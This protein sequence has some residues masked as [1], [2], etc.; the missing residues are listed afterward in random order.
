MAMDDTPPN[1]SPTWEDVRAAFKRYHQPE[2]LGRSPLVN[3]P[4][5]QAGLVLDPHTSTLKK[6]GVALQLVLKSAAERL[7]PPPGAFPLDVHPTIADPRWKDSTWQPYL[8]L[9]YHYMTS[10]PPKVLEQL[11]IGGSV[12]ALIALMGLTDLYGSERKA[13]RAVADLLTEQQDLIT[14][15]K[16]IEKKAS[17]HYC[18]RP[19]AKY[20]T[21]IL[22]LIAATFEE[23][24]P[25]AWLLEIAK[26]EGMMKRQTALAKLLKK[27]LLYQDAREYLH[28]SIPLRGYLQARYPCNG[29]ERDERGHYHKLIVPYYDESRPIHAAWHLYHS[30]E[31]D[32]AI[33]LV[34]EYGY[35][36]LDLSACQLLLKLWKHL[37]ESDMERLPWAW[38]DFQRVCSYHFRLSYPQAALVACERG[39]KACH[40]NLEKAGFFR[41]RQGKLCE[42]GDYQTALSFYEQALKCFEGIPI[43]QSQVLKDRAWIYIFQHEWD[44][45][46]QDLDR[47]SRLLVGQEALGQRADIYDGYAALYRRRKKL[48]VALKHAKAALALREQVG[49]SERVAYSHNALGL[50]YRE[51]KAWAAARKS[52]M[53]AARLFEALG[54]RAELATVYLNLGALDYYEGKYPSAVDWYQQSLDL[55][56]ALSLRLGQVQAHYNLAEGYA[57]MGKS[58]H[59]LLHWHLG[60]ALCRKE[61]QIVEQIEEFKKLATRYPILVRVRLKEAEVEVLYE[62]KRRGSITRQDVIS[63][64]R[65]LNKAASDATAKRLLKRLTDAKLLVMPQSGPTTHYFL[66]D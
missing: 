48:G 61:P 59:G 42:E 52:Y 65:R 7:A 19:L 49:D 9:R 32:K 44:K 15:A 20:A 66:T 45:A 36:T 37:K 24:F 31:K 40:A 63:I 23:P 58:T 46:K 16:E 27:H 4:L 53:E 2:E 13:F 64:L 1:Y 38:V 34:I 47:A 26:D 33:K 43:N 62:A 39:L 50:I 3:L 29:P 12:D 17:E 22:L 5:V 51:Q 8:M 41:H 54:R 25:K 28:L 21:R 11:G 56:C 18:T 55:F 35:Q 30:G 6:R 10:L 14:A 57:E 60:D